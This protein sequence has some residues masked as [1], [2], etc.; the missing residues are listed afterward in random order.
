MTPEQNISCPN[1]FPLISK[2]HS[3]FKILHFDGTVLFIKV[4]GF[5][6]NFPLGLLVINFIRCRIPKKSSLQAQAMKAT[7]VTTFD[8]LTR[9]H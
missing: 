1:Y 4:L 7:A 9:I 8:I 6:R 5:F 3:P 2:Q